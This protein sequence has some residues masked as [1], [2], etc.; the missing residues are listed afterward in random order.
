MTYFLIKFKHISGS[1]FT[2]ILDIEVIFKPKKI[3]ALLFLFVE[4]L[5]QKAAIFFNC[6]KSVFIY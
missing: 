6:T 1:P 3:G 2:S 4:F 5:V